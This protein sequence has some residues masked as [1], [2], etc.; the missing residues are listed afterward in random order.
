MLG[1]AGLGAAKAVV[2]EGG[3]DGKE[4]EVGEGGDCFGHV[5]CP[6]AAKA[7]DGFDAFRELLKEMSGVLEI[8]GLDGCI[9]KDVA[10]C[11]GEGKTEAL[12]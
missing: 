8:D 1:E 9:E 2:G 3:G 6:S 4:G 5:Q 10:A 11:R 7:D 12:A